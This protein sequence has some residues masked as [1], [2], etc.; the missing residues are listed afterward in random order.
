MPSKDYACL[1]WASHRFSMGISTIR[2]ESNTPSL[3]RNLPYALPNGS[4]CFP[5]S[6][7]RMFYSLVKACSP[8]KTLQGGCHALM[9]VLDKQVLK[10]SESLQWMMV[11]AGGG[12][13]LQSRQQLSNIGLNPASCT[14]D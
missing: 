14:A 2:A 4:P 7:S 10:L 13:Y 12:L 6:S 1:R 5:M 9:T 8:L 3:G 11:R